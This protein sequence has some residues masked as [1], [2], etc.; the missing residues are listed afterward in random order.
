MPRHGLTDAQWERLAPH[1]P[2]ER[3][4]VGR[5]SRPHREL[6]D[7]VLWVLATGSPWRDLPDE[8]GPWPS[9]YSRFRRWEAKGIW[10]SLLAELQR[11]ADE[12]G[13]IDWRLHFVDG[14]VVRAH[15]SAAGAKK[16][17]TRPSGT[18]EAASRPRSTPAARA[19]G[20]PSA[21]R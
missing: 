1:L 6:L 14:S 2:P 15:V 4:K 21:S 9:A 8:L 3:P 12:R 17:E 13:E 11:E 16:G 19:G 20:G 10:R 5:P 18:P 7:A